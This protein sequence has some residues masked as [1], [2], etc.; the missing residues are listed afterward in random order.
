MPRCRE[1]EKLC[2]QNVVVSAEKRER[3]FVFVKKVFKKSHN[4]EKCLKGEFHCAL[5]IL[6]PQIYVVVEEIVAEIISLLS[7]CLVLL[8]FL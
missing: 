5:A 6:E 8:P 2:L 3:E 4:S 7:G 1:N